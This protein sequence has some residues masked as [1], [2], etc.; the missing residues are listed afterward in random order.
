MIQQST[1][2]ER[3]AAQRRASDMTQAALAE[4]LGVSAQAV[5]QWERGE[6]M[7]DILLL[8]EIADVFGVTI[9]NLYGREEKQIPADGSPEETGAANG[10]QA[11]LMCG[12]RVVQRQELA[13]YGAERVV[14]RI[15]GDCEANVKSMFS[16][17]VEGDMSGD[18]GAESS[19][20]VYGDCGGDITCGGDVT[21][22]GDC[23]GNVRVEGNLTAGG[24]VSGDTGAERSV[25][26]DV[27]CHVDVPRGG[28]TC[29]GENR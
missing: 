25:C 20:Y 15:D 18:V 26:V 11:I 6:T 24:D 23:G 13:G 5:S 9:D 14:L 28:V 2:G 3:I 29:G 21:V 16:V 17:T 7:P 22:G 1:M 19:V 27:D 4:K 10:I 12:G 8:P